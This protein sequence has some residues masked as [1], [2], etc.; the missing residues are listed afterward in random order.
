MNYL[1]DAELPAYGALAREFAIC[2]RWFCSH[3]GGTLP[4]RFINLTGDLSEDVY[5]SPEVENPHLFHDF[6]PLETKTFFDHLTRFNVPWTLFEHN[7]STLR[8]F[9]KYTFDDRN[10]VGFKDLDRGF[11]AMAR[12]GT[13]PAVS[14]IEPD[15]IEAPGGNDDHAPADMINGQVLVATV[16]SALLENPEQWAKTLLIVAYDEHGGFYDHVALPF[17]ITTGSGA[18]ATTRNIAPLSNGERRLGVRVPAFVV[19]PYIPAM[20]NGQVNVSHTVYDH[21]SITATILR[22]FCS[23]RVPE[24][25]PRPKDAA[26][27]RELLTL[28]VPRPIEEF[29]TLAAEMRAIASWPTVALAGVPPTIHRRPDEGLEDFHGLVAFATTTTGK[30]A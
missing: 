4:N 9:R 12:A 25:G 2:D 30:G 13:L 21:T 26:D 29:A 17:E 20:A 18:N 8:M 3:I 5:G 22:R 10:V 11:A 27:L 6:A 14:F 19:S 24:M 1:T 15:Y 23:A 28:D 7:Y 16:L